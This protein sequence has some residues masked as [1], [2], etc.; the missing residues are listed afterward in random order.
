MLFMNIFLDLNG[1]PT[2]SKEHSKPLQRCA[3]V[4]CKALILHLCYLI[5]QAVLFVRMSNDMFQLLFQIM[6]RQ[7]ALARVAPAAQ[8]STQS[9]TNG[10]Y[11]LNLV[12]NDVKE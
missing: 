2:F 6:Q 4:S 8:E 1:T 11:F 12:L 7:R 5:L 9:K 10:L 3:K